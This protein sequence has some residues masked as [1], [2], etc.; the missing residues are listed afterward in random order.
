MSTTAAAETGPW[1]APAK[2]NLMLRVLGRRE[3]G[4][5]RLQTVF[6]FIDHCDELEFHTNPSGLVRLLNPQPDVPQDQDLVIRAARLLQAEADSGQGVDIRLHKRIPAG[7]G[8]GGGSSDAA[9]C[10]LAL[11]RLW[12]LHWPRQRLAQLGLR[13]GA[14]VPIFILGQAAWA[15]GVGE[16]L[17]PM[18]LPEPW[19]L[20]LSPA[21]QVSTGAVFGAAELTRDA[22]PIR[23]A[24]FRAGQVEN[25]CETLVRQRYPQ[26][27]AAMTWLGQHG[28]ARLTGTGATVFLDCV[29]RAEAEGLLQQ[30]QQQGFKGFVAKG[31]NQSPLLAKLQC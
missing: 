25:S 10:L 28:Q 17:T 8:L 1:P 24:A 22:A 20:C 2:L 6:Q 4:Y 29:G 11:N 19:Y 13:L 16:Q 15:E 9:T 7:A 30:A 31:M 27:D 18:D 26:V 3:D 12:R 14:D 21:C 5:H 23:I